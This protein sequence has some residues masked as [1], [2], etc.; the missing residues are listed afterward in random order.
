VILCIQ[1]KKIPPNLH[2][3]ILN[4]KIN[5]DSIPAIIPTVITRWKGKNRIVGMSSFSMSGT[6]VHALIQEPPNKLHNPKSNSTFRPQV[7]TI[8]AKSEAALEAYRLKYLEFCKS[9]PDL[10][11]ADVS[12]GMSLGRAAFPYRIALTTK[13]MIE[14]ASKLE[15][16]EL[17]VGKATLRK[18]AFLFT[19]QG[20]HYQ[21]MARNLYASV[22]FFASA[23]DSCNESFKRILGLPCLT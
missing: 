10:D 11:V 15:A 6:N 12:Y 1:N 23:L 13:S 21:G 8:S 2:L 7:M 18:I 17:K 14:F 19:G 3:K 9:N 22:P 4:P 16:Q 20:S 5:L